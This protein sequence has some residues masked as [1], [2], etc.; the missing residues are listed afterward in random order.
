MSTYRYLY[1]TVHESSVFLWPY[2]PASLDSATS[3]PIMAR[4]KTKEAKTRIMQIILSSKLTFTYHSIIIII[5]LMKM[6]YKISLMNTV[7][8]YVRTQYS[9]MV[10]AKKKR[11]SDERRSTLT[12]GHIELFYL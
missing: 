2:R 3:A 9:T 1:L 8:T 4:E 7:I 6:G 10:G 11:K 5:T 12:T